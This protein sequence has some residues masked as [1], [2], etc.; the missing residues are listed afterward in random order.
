M[1]GARLLTYWAAGMKDRGERCDLEAGMAKLY[2]SESAQEAAA[3]AIRILGGPGQATA[4]VVERLY[5]DTPLM[6]IGEGTNEIQRTIIAKNLLQRHGE[7]LGAL[8]SLEAEPEERRQMALAVRQ[9]VEREI[10]PAAVEDD[11]AGR[12]PS[13]SLDKLADLGLFGAVDPAEMGGLDLDGLAYAL[14]AEEI[15]RGSATVASVLAGHLDAADLILPPGLAPSSACGSCPRLASGKLR[16]GMLRRL[17]EPAVRELNALRH[18]DGFILSGDGLVAGPAEHADLFVLLAPVDEQMLAFVLEAGQPGLV[19]DRA[20]RDARAPRRRS[21]A[22][23]ARGLRRAGTQTLGGTAAPDA[24]AIAAAQAAARVREAAAAVGLAQAAFEAALRY[25]QQRSAFGVPICQHQAIQLKLADM[26]T[27]IAVARL[28]THRAAAEDGAGEAAPAHAAMA[29]LHAAETAYMVTLEAMRIHGGYGYSAEF[30]VERYYRDAPRSWRARPATRRFAAASPAT[31][32]PTTICTAIRREL[33][34]LLR[35]IRRRAGLQALAGTHDHRGRLHVVRA[36]DD[37]P[38][39]APLGRPL[40]RDV[41]PA[42]AAR[43]AGAARLQRRHRHDASPT[44]RGAPSPTSRWT[45]SSTRSRPSSATRS[46]RRAAC[47]SCASPGK[48]TAASSP[49]R[50]PRPTSGETRSARTR[51]RSSCRR[52]TTPTLG[53]GKLP[54]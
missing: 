15:G 37:E 17:R 43:G 13:A 21:L 31:P 28:L 41:Y 34:A 44:S 54:Y 48:A 11:R 7:R 50:P 29:H 5:R 52:R 22:R 33:R 27:A 39:P 42:Q 53:E 3:D 51:E 10:A 30:P 23:R 38:A 32:S 20:L 12:F 19:L 6:M 49:S 1:D 26:A 46:T 40:R 25:S 2:A 4:G 9:L 18:A 36:P 8:T 16:G 47:S 45:P 14:I 35:G 24:A